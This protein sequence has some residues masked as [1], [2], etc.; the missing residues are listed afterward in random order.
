MTLPVLSIDKEEEEEEPETTTLP[1]EEDEE[2]TSV[3][4]LSIDIVSEIISWLPVKSVIRCKCVCKDWY[5]LIENRSFAAKHYSRSHTVIVEIENNKTDQLDFNGSTIDENFKIRSTIAGFLLEKGLTS[6]KYRLRNF[7]TEEVI[8]LPNLHQNCFALLCFLHQH[9]SLDFTFLCINKQTH[10]F[11]YEYMNLH[12]DLNWR[13][14]E[15]TFVENAG[16]TITHLIALLTKNSFHHAKIIKEGLCEY[17]VIH[18]FDMMSKC[19]FRN[20]LPRGLFRD[21]SKVWCFH[22]KGFVGL[23]EVE[24]EKMS[25]ILLEDYKK[26]KWSEEKF[27]Y[28]L[29]YLEKYPDMKNV[30]VIEVDEKYV[31][32]S[33]DGKGRWYCYCLE[34]ESLVQLYS[35][36][37]EKKYVI[38][39]S[40]ISFKRKVGEEP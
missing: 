1:V 7:I 13:P 3:P 16:S 8:Y 38:T 2:E 10:D 4:I 24:G 34:T 12:R 19:C 37:F 28:D 39:P 26:G 11:T 18:S 29:K 6:K 9:T 15:F 32:F 40:L 14:L 27:V 22:W 33:E 25:V 20:T 36:G 5:D 35:K 31:L 30:A 17:I 21:V 23:G